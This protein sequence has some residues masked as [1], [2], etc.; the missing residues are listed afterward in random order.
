MW[1][2]NVKILG[3]VIGVLG[4]YTLVA[5]SIPQ[6]QSEVPR[7]IDMSGD[8]TPDQLVAIGARVFNGAGGCTTCHG[9]GTRAPNLLTGE[10]NLGP[11]GARCASRYNGSHRS[12]T[13]LATPPAFRARS[14]DS[15][16]PNMSCKDYL[17]ESITQ[18]AAF[19]VPGY[20]PIM[21]DMRRTLPPEQVWAVI[22]FLE[23]NG[24]TVDVTA[25]DVHAA[26][27]AAGGSGDQAAGGGAAGPPANATLDP[28][29]IIDAN[30][31]LGCHSLHGQGGVHVDGL[32]ADLCGAARPT[33]FDGVGTRLSRD[34]IRESI[35][36]PNAKI[37]PGFEKVAGVMPQTFGQMM[38]AA[39]LEA[40][41]TYLASLK[42]GAERDEFLMY[43]VASDQAFDKLRSMVK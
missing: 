28:R 36:L 26:M 6:I 32:T 2:T 38:T 39:Q 27:Q 16:K 10:G 9:L 3:L 15:R 14:T 5:N 42:S 29:K 35:L 20:Q 7:A 30:G 34:D 43:Q 4:L 22:A 19:V 17:F 12:P 37:A 24:G 11:I 8:I 23:S 33:H 13:H 41:V 1:R 40:L 25:D 21:P 31:C 18:P